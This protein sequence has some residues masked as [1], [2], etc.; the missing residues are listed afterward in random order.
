MRVAACRG[1]AGHSRAFEDTKQGEG[2]E[3]FHPSI[4][5]RE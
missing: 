4:G 1:L 5:V 2:V 3:G